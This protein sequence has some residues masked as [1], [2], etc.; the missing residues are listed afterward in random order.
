MSRYVALNPV[1]AGLADRAQDWERS[2]TRALIAGQDT[3]FLRVGPAL[4]RVGDL[5]AFLY[6]GN[7]QVLPPALSP[8]RSPRRSRAAGCNWPSENIRFAA[9]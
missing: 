4:E 9:E 8:F 1:R 2:S 7:A 3:R 6:P 5:A